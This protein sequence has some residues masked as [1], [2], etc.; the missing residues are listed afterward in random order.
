[1]PRQARVKSESGIYHVVLRGI[2]GQRIFEDEQDNQKFIEVLKDFKAVSEYTVFAY[3]LMG[4]HAHLLIKVGAEGLDRVFKRIGG[5]YVYWYNNKYRRRGHLFQDRYKSEP[6][7]NGAYLLTVLRYIHQ[8]PVRAGFCKTC[9]DY[10]NSSYREY[11]WAG[12]APL[13]DSGL[14]LKIMSREQFVQFHKQ[15]ANDRCL[16][17]EDD[18]FRLTDDRAKESIYAVSNCRNIAQFQKLAIEKRDQCV[19]ELK[20]QGLSIRQ[21]SRLTGLSFGIVRKL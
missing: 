3:C 9:G 11:L 21:I 5:R 1:M 14:A 13:A 2:N 18:S 17:A 8:N 12:D 19:K 16:D 20:A 15:L 10:A 6:V 4:N 7:E